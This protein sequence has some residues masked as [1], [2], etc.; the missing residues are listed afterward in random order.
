MAREMEFGNKVR[1]LDVLDVE[2]EVVVGNPL[3]VVD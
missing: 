2:I 3:E 1:N